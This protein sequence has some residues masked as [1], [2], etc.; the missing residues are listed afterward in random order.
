MIYLEEGQ[1]K[2]CLHC[3]ALTVV[4][5]GLR[6]LDDCDV[7]VDGDRVVA[8][9]VDGPLGGDR[10]GEGVRLEGVVDAHRDL[11]ALGAVGHAVGGRQDLLGRER[12]N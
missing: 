11:H 6:E 4:L 9:V 1:P 12:V 10:L 7:V 8:L 2:G 3:L 5:D